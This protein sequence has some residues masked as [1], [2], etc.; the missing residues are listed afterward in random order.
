MVTLGTLI[1]TSLKSTIKRSFLDLTKHQT[2]LFPTQ[3]LGQTRRKK[4]KRKKKKKK[5]KKKKKKEI[6]EACVHGRNGMS[7]S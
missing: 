5:R 2:L 4:K 7:Y 6:R 3:E 1:S